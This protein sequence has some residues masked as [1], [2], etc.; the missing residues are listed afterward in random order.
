MEKLALFGGKKAKTVP[1]STGNRFGKEELEQVKEALE[2]NTLF[3]FFG[4]KTKQFTEKF[5][6]MYGMKYCYTTSS[7]TAAV[8]TALCGIGPGDE[9]ITSPITDFGSVIGVLFQ[10]AIPVFA[11]IDPETYN[12]D[13]ENVEKAITPKT[14][15]IVVVHLAGNPC[16]M[17]GIMVVARKHNLLVVE[18]CAQSYLSYYKGKLVGTIGDVGAFSLNDFKHISAGDGGM[19]ITNDEERYKKGF[20]FADK[21]YNRFGGNQRDV[22]YLAPNYRI[23][24]LQSAVA[25]AQ[26]DKLDFICSSR[27]RYGEGL[28]AGIKDLDGVKIHKVRE[29]NKSSYWFYLM[30]I[31]EEKLGVSRDEF[32]KALVAEGVNA[33]TYLTN[34]VYQYPMF[35]N[36][37][38]FDGTKY[39]FES[40]YNDRKITYPD[41]LCPL[42]EK[43]LKQVIYLRVNEFFSE[44]D[45]KETVEA[46]R[47]VALYYKSLKK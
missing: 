7:G 38:A 18:D 46:I 23:S 16:D 1:Y 27:N 42:A 32:L 35:K 41:G 5:A 45:L 15:A 37:N 31:E 14:K 21:N 36:L 22:P 6:E 11:D 3:Y 19:C 25:I 43:A 34:C 13:P 12:M 9:V 2:Q 47:K 4:N 17:D 40:P 44:R 10:G 20:M 39:P 8:H 29:G 30:R 24:E 26:L 28:T 33:S